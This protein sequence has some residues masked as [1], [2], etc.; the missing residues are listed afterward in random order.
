MSI[1]KR[2]RYILDAKTFSDLEVELGIERD[3][4]GSKTYGRRNF[5]DSFVVK[6]MQVKFNKAYSTRLCELYEFVEPWVLAAARKL[7]EE[8]KGQDRSFKNKMA[9]YLS[10]TVPVDFD[11][12]HLEDLE[13]LFNNKG[14]SIEFFIGSEKYD[15]TIQMLLKFDWGS[16]L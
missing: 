13:S 12:Q 1:L 5:S 3:E 8:G 14:F 15:D 6:D 16:R 4:E 10:A 11:I 2:M 9:V 7:I